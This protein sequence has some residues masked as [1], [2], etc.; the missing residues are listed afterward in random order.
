[1]LRL[2]QGLTQRGGKVTFV[3]HRADAIPP[4]FASPARVV[5]LDVDRSLTAVPGLV[6]ELRRSRPDVLVSAFSHN[7][8]LAV[9]AG[10]LSRTGVSVVL[11][12][13][14]PVSLHVQMVGGLRYRTL[15]WL[16]PL[17]YRRAAS[18]VAVAGG[19][20]DD[21]RRLLAPGA[22]PIQ[23]IH[24]PVLP[25]NWRDLARE[26]VDHPWLNDPGLRTVLSVA[27]LS[28]EKNL[29]ALL[30]AFARVKASLPQA[31]LL[32]VGD[33]PQRPALEALIAAMG[34]TGAAAI[35]GWV[36]NPFAYMQRARVLVLS[37]DVEGFGNVLV[38]AMA[39]GTPVVSTDCPYGPGEVLGGGAYGD[40][41]PVG[42]EQ[43]LTEAI[44]RALDGAAG[45]PAPAGARERAL[46]FTVE[47]SAAQYLELFQRL[48][49]AGGAGQAVGATATWT[50]A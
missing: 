35:V 25:A 19:V 28:P 31:R 26:P 3:V 20:R 34:L 43:A 42:D 27:R 12:E 32:V 29:P 30:R 37:S 2:A 47:R 18:I 24:N 17:V 40:L 7:N 4:V 21:L 48:R 50:P 5:S 14:T 45:P 23:V 10:M 13:H 33:G 49:P 6:R 16:L 15:P 9:L 41:V 22:P 46:E 1:M 38:E 36:N 11:T 8:V 39:C 44:L